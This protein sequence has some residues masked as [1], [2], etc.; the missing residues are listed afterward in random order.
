MQDSSEKTFEAYSATKTSAGK[1]DVIKEITEQINN[2][3]QSSALK[4]QKLL[5]VER[6]AK[7]FLIKDF[8]NQKAEFLREKEENM[9]KMNS[10]F[11]EL[12]TAENSNFALKFEVL[13]IKT[14]NKA[15]IAENSRLSK[16]IKD[17]E[18][19]FLGKLEACRKKLEI[20]ESEPLNVKNL[21]MKL[22]D[23][24]SVNQSDTLKEKEKLIKSLN[25]EISELKI[26][27]K[28]IIFN[29]DLKPFNEIEALLEKKSKELQLPGQFI[30]D[31]EQNY[32][33]TNKKVVLLVKD[34]Q[35]CCKVGNSY[36]TFEDYVSCYIK[37]ERSLSPKLKLSLS[38]RSED[39]KTKKA[40][41]RKALNNS[42]SES[43][44]FKRII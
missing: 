31:Q 26:L 33:Y 42:T 38:Q 10:L 28:S 4:F 15:V 11:D 5:N 18:F 12:K 1:N 19:S 27:N 39:S 35:L 2:E 24:T 8:Q 37:Q 41:L 7:D 30:K 20:Y 17:L 21:L 16:T 22:E 40:I 14:E 6:K 44:G 29:R 13:K 36:K 43:K 25:K 9:K 32:T 3:L 23:L 34:G